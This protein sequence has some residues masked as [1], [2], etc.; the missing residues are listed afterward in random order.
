MRTRSFRLLLAKVFRA[1]RDIKAVFQAR[2]G[3]HGAGPI[4][5]RIKGLRIFARSTRAHPRVRAG[6]P[7]FRASNPG[8]GNF[9]DRISE[10]STYAV[11]QSVGMFAIKGSTTTFVKHDSA[12]G[13]AMIGADVIPSLSNQENTRCGF[14]NMR[15][16]VITISLA[17]ICASIASI[18]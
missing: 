17:Q 12:P 4:P 1:F 8:E 13:G 2:F 9:D 7:K 11:P 14:P 15:T 18:A 5:R 3:A 10:R 16:S 6:P